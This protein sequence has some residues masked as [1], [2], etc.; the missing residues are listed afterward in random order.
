MER[1]GAGIPIWNLGS[2]A[3]FFLELLLKFQTELAASL[4]RTAED[5]RDFAERL[6]G[7]AGIQEVYPSGGNFLLVRL[8]GDD[9]GCAHPLTE[10]L[11]RK[12]SIHVKD[13]SSKFG[14]AAPYLRLAV[15]RPAEN[16]RLLAALAESP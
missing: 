10:S 4:A 15:R 7:M 3:E 6:A 9:A 2:P 1:L 16:L 12:Y 11:L 14:N 8:A 5:R 13:V